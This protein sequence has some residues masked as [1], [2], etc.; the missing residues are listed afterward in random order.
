MDMDLAFR[1]E[2]TPLQK[3]AF[4]AFLVGAP[5][6]LAVAAVIDY[7]HEPL[8]VR[9]EIRQQAPAIR[10]LFDSMQA[11]TSPD[12]SNLVPNAGQSQT[13]VTAHFTV[14]FNPQATISISSGDQLMALI[15]RNGELTGDPAIAK[16]A[17]DELMARQLKVSTAEATPS[18]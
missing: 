5:L 3:V 4:G 15:D 8:S 7:E 14:G 18:K 17:L 11:E 10:R 16:Q 1:E 2:L 12:Q 9:D 13:V 6:T